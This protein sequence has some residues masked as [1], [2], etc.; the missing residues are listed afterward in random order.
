MLV[1]KKD[2]VFFTY[3]HLYACSNYPKHARTKSE[4]ALYGQTFYQKMTWF[5]P[6]NDQRQIR[7]E[8]CWY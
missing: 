1:K 2:S 7:E 3:W 5:L 6:K 4:S 8:I